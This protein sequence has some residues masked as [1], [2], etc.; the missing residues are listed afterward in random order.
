MKRLLE[1]KVK[2]RSEVLTDEEMKK[3]VGGNGDCYFMCQ[4]INREGGPR[5]Y[6]GDCSGP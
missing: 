4:C 6:K 5:Y 2:K 1:I 3:I